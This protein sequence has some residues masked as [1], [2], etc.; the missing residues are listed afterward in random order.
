[1]LIVLASTKYYAYIVARFKQ[2]HSCGIVGSLSQNAGYPPLLTRCIV[3]K[4]LKGKRKLF[5]QEYLIDRNATQAYIRAGYAPKAAGQCGFD[6]LKKPEIAAELLRLYKVR[7][8][9]VGIT[10]DDVLRK[11]I[12]VAE[13]CM[14]EDTYD[15]GAAIRALEVIAKHLGMFEKDN[16]QQSNTTV[17][18]VDGIT[19]PPNAGETVRDDD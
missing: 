6:L 11:L 4:E 3:A 16:A 2:R 12:S 14:T 1:M 13:H 17:L 18:V 8:D 15:A 5:C 7:A 10:A 19:K 9:H